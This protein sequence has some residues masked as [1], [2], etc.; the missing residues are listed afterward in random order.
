MH[1]QTPDPKSRLAEGVAPDV[2]AVLADEH[3]RFLRFLERR[4]ASREQAEEI[5]Q[6]AFVRAL[7]RGHTLRD[8]ESAT[9]W[10]YRLLRNSLVDHYRRQGAERRALEAAARTLDPREQDG[11]L[12]QAIC[13][14]VE[15]LLGTLKPSY[16]EILRRVELEEVSVAQ[17]AHELGISAS[18]AGVRIHRAR[19]ALFRQLVL[20][21]G[22]CATHGCLDC[23]CQARHEGAPGD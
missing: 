15:A 11:E 3:V 18:N 6:Q 7:E 1:D 12:M 21:C 19:E 17:A 20:S 23:H 2:V 13:Q 8:G 22:T 4:V 5:L 9:A 16:S 14:C 10:F